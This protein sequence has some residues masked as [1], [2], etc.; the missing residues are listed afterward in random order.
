M[1]IV[2]AISLVLLTTVS[3]AAQKAYYDPA[4]NKHIVDVSGKKPKAD[5]EREFGLS[6]PQEVTLNAGEGTRV[7]NGTLTKY[8][9]VQEA[10]DKAAADKKQKKDKIEAANSVDELK[11]LLKDMIDG[12]L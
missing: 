3:Y 10:K 5:I 4:T 12:K 11:K 1:R 6:A 9:I 2:I 8:N 7:V